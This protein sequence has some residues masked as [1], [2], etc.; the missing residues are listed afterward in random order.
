M[1]FGLSERAASVKLISPEENFLNHFCAV[2]SVTALSP[3]ALHTFR[4]TT[5]ALVP[6]GSR[7]GEDNH[8]RTDGYE[9]RAEDHPGHGD[10]D[11]S[12]RHEHEDEATNARAWNFQV[13]ALALASESPNHPKAKEARVPPVALREKARWM[14]V[15]AE[16]SQQGVR[17]TK[18]V[19]T[20]VGIRMQ[21]ASAADYRQLVCIVSA[22]E[23]QYLSYQLR[24]GRQPR[25]LR[26]DHRGGSGPRSGEP[27]I[28]ARILQ[29]DSSW[30]ST[31]S[32][33]AYLRPADE[34]RRG[35]ED[36]FGDSCVR[37][38]CHRRVQTGQEGPRPHQTAECTKPRDVPAKCA[39]CSGPQIASYRGCA[40]S[41][42]NNRREAPAPTPR[43]VA[44]KPAPRPALKRPETR[45]AQ[46][47]PP[48]EAATAMEMDASRPSTSTVKP[49]CAAA[50]KKSAAK[51]V[52]RK[53]KASGK[54]KSPAAT[55]RPKKPE[56]PKP[57]KPAKPT[58]AKTPP[59]RPQ[60]EDRQDGTRRH[61]HASPA[62]P[63]LPE[64]QQDQATRSGNHNSWRADQEPRLDWC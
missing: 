1:I 9:D 8:A 2:R 34:E 60:D 59:V 61:E 56:T 21:P 16:L 53:P 57:G 14:A 58:V 54:P 26:G 31:P 45:K 40:K 4:I 41:P 17:T 33:T 7:E 24:E 10:D 55:T 38:E 25:S 62:D 3:N 19:N 39:L 37:H 29:K 36:L 49:S 52:A 64:D 11:D 18:M 12:N 32:D 15:N 43:P 27:R 51:I 5:V 50:V 30:S 23:I 22:M 20:N 6:D 28:P 47:Q 63:I 35:K 48:K 13:D 46:S 44:P 42:Y